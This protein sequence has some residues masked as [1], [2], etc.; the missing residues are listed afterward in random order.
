[1]L[2]KK[3][4][5]SL[6]WGILS[7]LFC[8]V[9]LSAEGYAVR[10]DEAEDVSLTV[11]KKGEAY[12]LA[13]SA[14]PHEAR[15]AALM[16]DVS[17]GKGDIV[18]QMV[19]E[20]KAA[21]LNLTLG[22]PTG[23]RVRVLLDGNLSNTDTAAKPLPLLCLQMP[24]DPT[25]VPV[26]SEAILWVKFSDRHMESYTLSVEYVKSESDDTSA[27][28]TDKESDTLGQEFPETHRQNASD[29][30][31]KFPSVPEEPPETGDHVPPTERGETLYLGCRE[32]QAQ[33][34]CFSIKLLFFAPI[35]ERIPAVFCTG[36]GTLVTLTIHRVEGSS[37]LI[38]T[39]RGLCA[40]RDVRFWV[41]SADGIVEIRYRNA[42][43]QSHSRR[44][45]ERPPVDS[46]R[47]TGGFLRGILC[48]KS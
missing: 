35:D 12:V 2:H 5:K 8:M 1:M 39:F 30:T 14:L 7:V 46:S 24:T 13:L 22:P 27:P 29:E 25:Y 42:A 48:K 15:S 45:R 17:L 9:C 34:G 40:E 26:V 19:T 31:E 6:V 16:F 41:E 32:S 33:N 21:H 37:V 43:F 23:G 20:E 44:E 36:G 3:S 38:Y 10:S 28:M 11:Q 47:P 18:P 4:Y